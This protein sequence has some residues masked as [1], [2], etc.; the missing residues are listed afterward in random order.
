M[1]VV[2]VTFITNDLTNV[3]IS[4]VLQINV[5][6]LTRSENNFEG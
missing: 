2:L 6:G 4:P 5:V 3:N 1:E